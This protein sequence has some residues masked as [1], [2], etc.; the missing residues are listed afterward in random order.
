MSWELEDT[1]LWIRW[2]SQGQTCS[3]ESGPVTPLT[4]R[5][6]VRVLSITKHWA[7]HQH[8]KALINDITPYYPEKCC[9]SKDVKTCSKSPIFSICIYIQ[10]IMLGLFIPFIN[11]LYHPISPLSNQLRG[12]YGPWNDPPS[13]RDTLWLWLTVRHGKSPCY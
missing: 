9:W 6:L 11:G 4:R 13:Y 8:S 5:E 2:A 3:L 10:N 12:P 7:K 1:L